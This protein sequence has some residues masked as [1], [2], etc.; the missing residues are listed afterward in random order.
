[1]FKNLA[2][3][4]ITKPVLILIEKISSLLSNSEEYFKLRHI[5]Q[6]FVLPHLTKLKSHKFL[7]QEVYNQVEF[8]AFGF[9]RHCNIGKNGLEYLLEDIEEI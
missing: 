5:Y 7:S 1:M 4:G 6:N 2:S 3:G 8:Y 9:L